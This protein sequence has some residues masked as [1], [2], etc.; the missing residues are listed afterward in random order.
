MFALVDNPNERVRR[1]LALRWMLARTSQAPDVGMDRQRVFDLPPIA[2]R[3]TEHRLI[4]RRCAYGTTIRGAA[5]V[6]A[7]ARYGPRM[8]AIILYL[9]VGWA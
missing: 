7:P 4:A 5:R 2:V 3:V 9:Y 8:T 1:D 6:T